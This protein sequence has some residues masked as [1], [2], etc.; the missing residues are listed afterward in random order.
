MNRMYSFLI[1][2]DRFIVLTGYQTY[3]IFMSS[4]RYRFSQFTLM[5]VPKRAKKKDLTEKLQQS[6]EVLDIKFCVKNIF[7]DLHLNEYILS[8][9]AS[10]M[11]FICIV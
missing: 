9:I 2:Y 11:I 8:Q 3:A 4:S 10:G 7:D 5:R 1:D 6:L